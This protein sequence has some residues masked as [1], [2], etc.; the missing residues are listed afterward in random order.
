MLLAAIR[1]IHFVQIQVSLNG[2]CIFVA[3]AAAHTRDIENYT[4]HKIDIRCQCKTC[5]TNKQTEQKKRQTQQQQQ[6]Q[7]LLLAGDTL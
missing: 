3:A 4:E 7:Q 2:N 1:C 5:K 6:R